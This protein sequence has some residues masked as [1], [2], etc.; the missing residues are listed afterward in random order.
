MISSFFF[1]K[2]IM[3]LA[4]WYCSIFP[5]ALLLAAAA[6]LINYYTD[7]FSLLRTW[8]R[9][10]HV[11]TE[12]STY[13]RHYFFS[14]ALVFLAAMSSFYWSA[15]PFDNLC[16]AANQTLDEG[17]AGVYMVT[18]ADRFKTSV[19]MEEIELTANRT[20]YKFCDQDFILGSG[21]TQYPFLEGEWMDEGQQT[22]ATLFA[23]TSLGVIVMIATK[24]LVSGI[25]YCAR[26]C[27]VNI[28]KEEVM[29]S[30]RFSLG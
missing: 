15:Y 29:I 14:S 11:S 16:V 18:I 6:L 2:K 3:F 27:A 4:F 23:W 26:R 17:F 12:I 10:P 19:R 9:A 24:F 21:G 28:Y 1:E 20:L 7:K 13:S 22:L 5:S 30:R 25:L 8:K